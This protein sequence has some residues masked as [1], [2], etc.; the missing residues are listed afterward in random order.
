MPRVARIW[1]TVI[2][3]IFG[4]FQKVWIKFDFQLYETAVR[5]INRTNYFTNFAWIDWHK[6]VRLVQRNFLNI[7][8]AIDQVKPLVRTMFLSWVEWRFS[9]GKKVYGT[10]LLKRAG[11]ECIRLKGSVATNE[12]MN[13][14]KILIQNFVTIK[15]T[16]SPRTSPQKTRRYRNVLAL[17][18]AVL[19]VLPSLHNPGN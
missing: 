14:V 12:H 18:V 19:S 9:K 17:S 10:I 13:H 3:Q 5:W 15:W 16:I 4:K 7:W 1:D 8:L 11:Y 6:V 2:R